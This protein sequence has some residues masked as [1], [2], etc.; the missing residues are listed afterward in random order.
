MWVA[1]RSL[2]SGP[3]VAFTLCCI[4]NLLLLDAPENDL[5]LKYDGQ[6]IWIHKLS[7][8]KLGASLLFESL[9]KLVLPLYSCLLWFTA[10]QLSSFNHY[11]IFFQ[12][13]TNLQIF[14]PQCWVT[15]LC[16][17]WMTRQGFISEHIAPYSS[18]FWLRLYLTVFCECNLKYYL[19][20]VRL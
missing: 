4:L 7:L 17:L 6:C 5:L 16:I 8:W 14:T 13:F 3:L 19:K 1:S 18:A 9:A 15:D 20:L 11:N 2:M 10:S 12:I